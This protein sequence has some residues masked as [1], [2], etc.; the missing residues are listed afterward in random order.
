MALKI[1]IDSI[2]KQG[3]HWHVDL[4]LADT[5]TPSEKLDVMSVEVDI[6]TPGSVAAAKEFVKN[7]FNLQKQQITERAATRAQVQNLL[8]QIEVET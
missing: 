1:Y 6:G 8:D 4:Y 2:V 7:R 3:A 5:A